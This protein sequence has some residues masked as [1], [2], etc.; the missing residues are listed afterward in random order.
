MRGRYCKSGVLAAYYANV[1]SV[2]EYSSVI[3]AG[4]AGT[5]LERLER[6]QHKFL[7]FLAG[8]RRDRFDMT[9]YDG[10]CASYKVNKLAK[11]RTALDLSF[12]HG[13]L[14]GRIDS[15]ILLAQFSL[16]APARPTRNPEFLF[17]PNSRIVASM[18]SV[19][20][21]LP[22]GFNTFLKSHPSYDMFFDSKSTLLRLHYSDV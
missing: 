22:R 8:T 11:R 21:R 7:S 5:H 1:R 4:A 9:D 12:L 16:R 19:F 3:W 18:S 17:V 20:S 13:V 6:I 15:S 10:L 14:S 2:L